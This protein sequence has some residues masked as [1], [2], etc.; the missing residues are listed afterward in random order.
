[1]TLL[2]KAAIQRNGA[3]AGSRDSGCGA[4]GLS[5]SR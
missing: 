2:Y 1:M 3:V 4:I 5:L